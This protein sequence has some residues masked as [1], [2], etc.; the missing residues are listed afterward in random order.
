VNS[1]AEIRFHLASATW[2]PEY[3]RKKMADVV[4]EQSAACTPLLFTS[5]HR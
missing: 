3:S 2:M 5:A 1:K 4:S